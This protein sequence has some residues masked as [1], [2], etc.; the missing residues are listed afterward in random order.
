MKKLL[1]FYYPDGNVETFK[2]GEAGIESINESVERMLVIMV[3]DKGTLFYTGI[4][5][6]CLYFDPKEKSK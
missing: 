6:K 2:E 3:T 4:P 5:Y 1:V